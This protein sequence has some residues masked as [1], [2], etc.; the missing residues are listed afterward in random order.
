[1]KLIVLLP[2]LEGR[3]VETVELAG[4]TTYHTLSNLRHDTE[5]IVTIIPLYN[6]NSEGP[7]ATARFK[8]GL[9]FLLLSKSFLHIGT[10]HRY[11][12]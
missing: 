12:L 5:Y 10:H 11:F 3:D 8:I 6:G 7:V 1:M 2:S 4:D 9:F